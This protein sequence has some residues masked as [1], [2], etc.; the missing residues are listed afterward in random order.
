M[1][2]RYTRDVFSSRVKKVLEKMPY[3]G[4]GAD[5]I[6]GFP[7]ETEDD[8]EDTFSFLE[9]SAALL[10]ACLYVFRKTRNRCRESAGKSSV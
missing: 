2:R 10:F 5:V 4:I 1:R 8:F 7:G 9:E 3:A 6:V